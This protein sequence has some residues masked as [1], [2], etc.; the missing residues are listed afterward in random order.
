MHRRNLL[1][2]LCNLAYVKKVS[3]T[4][5]N[6]LIY[7]VNRETCKVH[8]LWGCL[9]KFKERILYN[10]IPQD[11]VRN[12]TKAIFQTIILSCKLS[13]A[14]PWRYQ[15]P[16]R[17]FTIT[18]LVSW[19]SKLCEKRRSNIWNNRSPYLQCS[20]SWD[21]STCAVLPSYIYGAKIPFP[22]CTVFIGILYFCPCFMRFIP[23]SVFYTQP[24]I[25]TYFIFQSVVRSP[26]SIFYTDRVNNL[27]TRP[28][29]VGLSKASWYFWA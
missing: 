2:M 24:I 29:L 22:S 7:P 11:V 23:G 20:P 25:S 16:V 26:Q 19:K 18:I 10:I 28:L 12:T 14:S 8:D 15:Q 4:T 5:L 6:R 21:D 3:W 13:I 9:Y 17:H 1:D 27:L